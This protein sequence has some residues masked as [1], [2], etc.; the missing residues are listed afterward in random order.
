MLLGGFIDD[1]GPWAQLAV[2]LIAII[3][4]VGL[5]GR[6][7]HNQFRDSVS[8]IVEPRF[9]AI[10]TSLEHVHECVERMGET[11]V[12][13]AQAAALAAGD[14]KT[15]ARAA[16]WAATEA[17]AAVTAHAV[18]M[19]E[20]IAADA[21]SFEQQHEWQSHADVALRNIQQGQAPHVDV[22]T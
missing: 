7:L 18:A 21:E 4:G 20:H 10:T 16:A 22:S 17:R 11:A 9:Q 2:A 1:I 8:E 15:A 12:A 6:W 13:N 3:T 19:E 14:A 5:G